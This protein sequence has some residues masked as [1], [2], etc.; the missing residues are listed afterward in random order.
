MRRRA[1]M[2]IAAVSVAAAPRSAFPQSYPAKALSIIVPY[3]AGGPTDT[4]TRIL[5]E[6][7]QRSLG[8]SVLVDNVT[9]ASGAVG[10]TK[11]A[12]AAPD[13]Y[14]LSVGH[15]GS[16]ITIW[17]MQPGSFELLRDLAPVAMFAENPLFLSARK[18]LEPRDLAALLAWLKA[19][20]DKA[21]MGGALGTIGHMASLDLVQRTGVKY[22]FVPY[23][24]GAPAMQDLMSGQIDLLID[25]AANSLPQLRAGKIK[26]YAVLAGGRLAVAPDIP[27]VDEAGLPGFHVSVW[28]AIWVPRATPAPVIARLNTA[29]REALAG[30]RLQQRFADLGQDIP[31]GNMQTAS[32]LADF[33]KAEVERWAPFLKAANLK[34]D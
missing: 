19:N 13:G 2:Q 21:S 17:A 20:P 7:M 6:A 22:Q 26:V 10:V 29:I 18:D 31:P 30:D 32:A 27:T 8:Q 34:S 3:P 25:Q 24:G 11:A 9:G 33:Q 4:L 15:A 5:A 1:F 16:H 28:H 14:T 12:R 23:R